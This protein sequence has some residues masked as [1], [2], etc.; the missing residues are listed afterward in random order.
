MRAAKRAARAAA[1]ERRR[2]AKA[3]AGPDAARAALG[4]LVARVATPAGAVVSGYWPMADE[5]DDRPMLAHFAATG[6]ACALP[7]VVARGEPLVFRRWRPGDALVTSRLGIE[8][9]GAN[10]PVT[11]PTM[12]LVP[13]LAFDGEGNR[14]G[15]GGG[16]YDRS[17]ARLRAR[18]PVLAI[19]VAF[20]GQGMEEVPHGPGDQRLDWIVTENGASAFP[21]TAV[22]ASLS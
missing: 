10:A 7:V 2:I 9:P 3:M 8:E 19:G 14:L 18:G 4:H 15:Y 13:L 1:L 16:F 5:F 6:H 22:E 12:L 17:L 11:E 21:Q 20:A